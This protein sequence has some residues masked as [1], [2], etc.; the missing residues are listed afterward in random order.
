M[1]GGGGEGW[2]ESTVKAEARF[3]PKNPRF[4]QIYFQTLDK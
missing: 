1:G 3:G 4:K 2:S